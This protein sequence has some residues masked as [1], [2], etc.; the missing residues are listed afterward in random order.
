VY[1]ILATVFFVAP[2]GFWVD[3]KRMSEQVLN[4]GLAKRYWMLVG[5]QW[6]SPFTGDAG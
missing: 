6:K 4:K 2:E 1:E 5:A 3:I